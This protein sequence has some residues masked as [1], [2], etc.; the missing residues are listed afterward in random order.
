MASSL[1]VCSIFVL[2][3]CQKE[4]FTTAPEDKIGFSTD[5]LRFD[6]VFTEL[7]SATR[8][9]KIYNPHKESIRISRIWLEQGSASRFNINVDG[10]PGDEHRDLEIAPNDSMY[11]FAEVTVNPD[12][13]LSASPF[14]IDENLLFETNGNT[15]AVVLEAWG[16]NANYIPSRFSADSIT[17]FGC[18]GGEW[19]WD[20]PRPYVLYG[21]V[22]VDNCTVRIPAGARIHVHGGLTR[23]VDPTSGDVGFYNDGIFVFSGSGRLLVEGTKEK[24]VI[25][26]SDR[27]EPE[28]ADVPGQWT[29]IWLQGGTTG[30]KLEH[31]IIRNSII[32]IRADSAVDLSLRNTQIYNTAGS[33]LIGVHA[34]INAQNCLFWGNTGFGIQ[35]EYGGNYQFDYCT[36]ASYGVDGEAVKLGNTI[37][38]D[39]PCAAYRLNKLEA[40]FRN[41]ILFGSKADQFTLFDRE[42]NP[43]NFDYRLENCIVRVKDLL[44]P[45]AWPDFLDRCQPC[46]NLDNR[47]T[48]FLDINKNDFRLDSTSSKA[49]AF[50]APIP[51]ILRDL[52]E[53]DRDATRPDVGCYELRL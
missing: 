18:D 38:L 30:H 25:F 22:F 11:I 23:T 42:D 4:R 12:Q 50:G 43:D 16:Q 49:N 15:Q 29:G 47:D 44:K 45:T 24:P 35:I 46:L 48:I 20:D 52:I 28:F 1:L 37:C 31:C 40:R 8:I 13:P 14:V 21:V 5:T 27:I 51:N 3:N 33:G 2:T 53:Q 41:C 7:G 34:N 26:E 32:G 39:Q 9:L 10:L 19:I 36:V 6:T 17:G